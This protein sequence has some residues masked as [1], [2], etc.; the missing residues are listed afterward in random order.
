MS[1]SWAADL[2]RLWLKLPYKWRRNILLWGATFLVVRIAISVWDIGIVL[3]WFLLIA[4]LATGLAERGV[5]FLQRLGRW[6]DQQAW[7]VIRG[8]VVSGLLPPTWDRFTIWFRDRSLFNFLVFLVPVF[9][10]GIIWLR[11]M[12]PFLRS[13]G[14]D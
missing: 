3:V 7:S 10:M 5:P 6:A 11:F 1:T 9:L 2:W 12:T 4:A 8:M 14:S 13:K